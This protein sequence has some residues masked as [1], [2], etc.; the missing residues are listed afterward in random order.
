MTSYFFEAKRGD[1][2]AAIPR[3]VMGVASHYT[4]HGY[5]LLVIIEPVIPY[6]DFQSFK[7]DPR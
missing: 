5:A 1:W 3:A 7:Q 2:G 6:L 4:Q